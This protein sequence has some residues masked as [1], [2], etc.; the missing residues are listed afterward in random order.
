[1]GFPDVACENVGIHGQDYLRDR[2]VA[3]QE[4]QDETNVETS[5]PQ[6]ADLVV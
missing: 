6:I 4:E 2:E 1:M 5:T 3:A